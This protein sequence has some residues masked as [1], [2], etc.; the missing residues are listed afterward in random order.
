MTLIY[1]ITSNSVHPARLSPAYR[2]A[3]KRATAKPLI[4]MRHTLSN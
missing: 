1:P 3:I 2:S 4:P